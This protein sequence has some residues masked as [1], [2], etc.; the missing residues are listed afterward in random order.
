MKTYGP[1]SLIR[2]TPQLTILD[3]Q[4]KLIKKYFPKATIILINGYESTKVMNS[5]PTGIIHIENERH[6]TTNVVRSIGLGLR[7]TI[8]NKVL[9][10]YGDLVCNDYT[11][12][13][14]LNN[15][16]ML[17][18]DTSNTMT[19]NEVGCTILDNKIEHLIYDLPTKWAQIAYFVD[20]E[21]ELLKQ[22]TWNPISENYLGFEVINNI[23]D[24]GGRFIPAQPEGLQANDV[25][26]TKD[27]YIA[28]SLI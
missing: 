15:K 17:F 19:E 14:S 8:T 9:L 10:M 5:Y 23:I 6:A 25:D 28:Q 12:K 21:L 20:M 3:Y 1:K 22:I 4:L 26:C 27:L 16:S 24:K 13:Q 7:A 11:F 2:L 18:I